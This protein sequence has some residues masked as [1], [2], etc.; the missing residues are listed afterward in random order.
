MCFPREGRVSSIAVILS[1]S[2]GIIILRLH[3][4]ASDLPA[5]A[6]IFCSPPQAAA[7]PLQKAAFMRGI[8]LCMPQ[9]AAFTPLLLL[10]ER[11]FYRCGKHRDRRRGE[12]YHCPLAA[13]ELPLRFL[14]LRAAA[15]VLVDE[16]GRPLVFERHQVFAVL[17][18]GQG[19]HFLLFLLCHTGPP[20]FL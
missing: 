6:K 8:V 10:G 18:I 3:F 9:A 16:H 20:F 14:P 1:V 17:F 15:A 11:A 12:P 13:A 5:A 19:A 7:F 2:N 4:F